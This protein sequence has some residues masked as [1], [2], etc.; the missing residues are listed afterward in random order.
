MLFRQ[1]FDLDT[2]TYTYLLADEDTREAVLID[3]VREQLER[4]VELLA[5]LELT[6]RW[7]LETHVHA[8]HVTSAGTLRSRLGARTVMSKN[9]GV[10][11]ADLA[12]E[13]GEV[14]RFGRHAIEVRHTPGHTS[15]DASFVVHDEGQA[16]TGDTLLIRG[17]GRTDFQQ[18]NARALYRSVHEKIFSLPDNTRL[19]PAHDYKGRT[20]TTVGE[21]KRL[22]PR[23][24]G[25][26]SM[27][28]FVA[29]M[30]A[31]NLP[32]PA[33]IDEA[34]PANSN[35]GIPP[36]AP[37]QT[38]EDGVPEVSVRWVHEASDA[39]AARIVDVREL[40]EWSGEQGR[41]AG[42][43]HVP[44][45]GVLD[46]AA[47]W[48]PGDKLVV[49]CRSGR[50]SGQAAHALTKAG[51]GSVVSMR[52]GMLAWHAAGYDVERG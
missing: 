16:F 22:N 41:I 50:R 31:L 6:L 47:G 11:C 34:L 10:H 8:D 33:N 14:I 4:D 17:C 48:D 36:W 27:E 46:V 40:A 7:V 43:Q 9:A 32:Y 24:G 51:F 2:A 49:V 19:Y 44:L 21:E 15:G 18:G 20:F 37:V 42:A 28:E 35:C 23:L 12:A 13:D 1:L 3:P 29:I 30:G 45:A 25:G 38:S 5:E 52:G 39:V 26:K